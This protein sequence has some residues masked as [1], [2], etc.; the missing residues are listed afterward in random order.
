VRVARAEV[1]EVSGTG[2]GDPEVV[3]KVMERAMRQ[4]D[5][6]KARVLWKVSCRV[7][8]FRHPVGILRKIFG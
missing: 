3:S 7:G 5:I 4:G 2:F 8:S 6:A 1:E